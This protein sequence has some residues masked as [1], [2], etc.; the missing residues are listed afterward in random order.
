[1]PFAIER[2]TR[3]AK[4]LAGSTF[5]RAAQTAKASHAIAG[6]S[7]CR[8][9]IVGACELEGASARTFPSQKTQSFAQRP[10]NPFPFGQIAL[11]ANPLHEFSRILPAEDEFACSLTYE[12]DRKSAR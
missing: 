3:P 8:T 2:P 10:R 5:L 11:F 4:W 9:N 7:I 1:M 6:I 12:V